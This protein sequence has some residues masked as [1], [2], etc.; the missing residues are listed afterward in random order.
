MKVW[1]V[2]QERKTK[3]NEMEVSVHRRWG[4][5]TIEGKVAKA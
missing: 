4:I 5:S 1:M 3:I 2:V